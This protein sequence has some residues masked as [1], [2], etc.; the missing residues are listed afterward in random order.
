[1]NQRDTSERLQKL[2]S[3][4]EELSNQLATTKMEADQLRFELT[5]SKEQVG[6]GEA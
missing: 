4:S 3:H 2:Q 6:G 5:N 1:M